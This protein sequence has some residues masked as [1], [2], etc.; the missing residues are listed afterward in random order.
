MDYVRQVSKWQHVYV[1]GLNGK[2]WKK[3]TLIVLG[4]LEVR[5]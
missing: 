4:F 3:S 5:F 2:F 1:I